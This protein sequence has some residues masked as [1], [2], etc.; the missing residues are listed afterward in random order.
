MGTPKGEI[1]PTGRSVELRLCDCIRIE[2]GK[3]YGSRIYF[4]MLDLLRQLGKTP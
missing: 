4:D 1:A 2:D 3:S